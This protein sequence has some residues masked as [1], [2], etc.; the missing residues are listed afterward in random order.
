VLAAKGSIAPHTEF[1]AEVY[2]LTKEEGGRHT[3]FFGGYTPQFF[4]RTTD[5]TGAT[6]VLG[7]AEMAMPGEP[8]RIFGPQGTRTI[9]HHRMQGMTWNLVEGSPGE[10]HV[11]ELAD[12]TVLTSRYLACE[13]FAQAKSD[14]HKSGAVLGTQGSI[15]KG[16]ESAHY[17]GLFLQSTQGGSFWLL[18]RKRGGGC[19][20]PPQRRP[21][22][23]GRFGV[24]VSSVA[25]LAKSFGQHV[26]HRKSWRLS[27]RTFQTGGGI[28]QRAA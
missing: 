5:V 19:R 22:W 1:E 16:G 24:S 14:T 2:V 18:G 28:S 23:R 8:V 7:D 6:E 9:I 15:G 3:P 20:R 4:F 21:L 10:V 11:A 27:L 12:Q 26:N 17:P 25:K 13:G